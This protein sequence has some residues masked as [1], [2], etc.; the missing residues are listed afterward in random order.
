MQHVGCFWPDRSFEVAASIG[1]FVII[2]H[3]AILG[4]D[5]GWDSGTADRLRESGLRLITS[6]PVTAEEW[7]LNPHRMKQHLGEMRQQLAERGLLERLIGMLISEEWY[8]GMLATPSRIE[9][10]VSYQALKAQFDAMPLDVQWRKL[11][12]LFC[13][14]ALS[15]TARAIKQVFPGV[16]VGHVEP[17]WS[18]DTTA[19]LRYR[20]VPA[21]YDFLC[22]DT[23]LEPLASEWQWQS[24]IVPTYR[25]AAR[26]GKPIMATI[27]TFR[28]M[29]G[30]PWY[31]FPDPIWI[32]KWWS[33]PSV[34]PQIQALAYFCC[35]H[36]T[37]YDARHGDGVDRGR[38]LTDSVAHLERAR[39]RWRR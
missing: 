17:R 22:M 32:D 26:A 19:G 27:Q 24:L 7:M 1:N 33:L 25:E 13:E 36:P 30:E 18:N 37:V 31:E 2:P 10:W 6:P 5:P 20:P 28:G 8:L 35:E 15:S 39:A 29:P 16:L 4:I 3:N 12:D 11:M 9:H 21:D 14:H 23:Y 38:G 34:V